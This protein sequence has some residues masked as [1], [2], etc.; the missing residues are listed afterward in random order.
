MIGLEHSV[1]FF[2]FKI[3]MFLFNMMVK[4]IKIK[5]SFTVRCVSLQMRPWSPTRRMSIG[6]LHGMATGEDSAKL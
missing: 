2:K 6:C 4:Q 3:F 5:D 1:L